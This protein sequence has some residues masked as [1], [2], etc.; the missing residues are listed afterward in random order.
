MRGPLSLSTNEEIGCL[1]EGFDTPPM[2]MMPHH[3]PYQGGLIE[4]AGLTKL[5]DLYAWRYQVGDVPKRARKA[6]DEIEAL[7][8]VVTRHVDLKKLERRRAHRDGRFQRR[9][10]RQLGFRPAHRKRAGQ[11]GRRTSG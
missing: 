5:K 9:L 7:P 10:E 8:E 6:H 4:K 2:F 11:D 3:R 1:V